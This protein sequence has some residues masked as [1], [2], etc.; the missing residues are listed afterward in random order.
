MGEVTEPPFR[1]VAIAGLGLIGGSIALGLRRAWPGVRVIGVDRPDVLAAARRIG[2]IAEDRRRVSEL[3]DAQVVVLAAPVPDIV[4]LL[5][6]AGDA[7][8]G[9]L[10]TDVGSTKRRIM[11]AA[12]AGSLRF[13]GGHP[14]AGAASGGLANAR[15]DLFEGREWLVVP[16]GGDPADIGGVERLV[17]VLGATSRRVDADEHDRLMAYVSHLPQLLATALMSTA[18]AAVGAG[19]LTAAGPGFAD[20]TRL[21]SS[22]LEIWRGILDT[23]G[24]YIAEAADALVSALPASSTALADRTR[25]DELFE[26]ANQWAA[27]TSSTSRPRSTPSSWRRPR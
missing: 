13:V 21:A 9:A 6:E 14:I 15:A 26:R 16:N 20:M 27:T 22:P 11:G 25:I 17:A 7:S 8:L 12:R 10:I 3:E 19:G 4:Q 24:D 5:R 23:N 18:G 1:S 2:A